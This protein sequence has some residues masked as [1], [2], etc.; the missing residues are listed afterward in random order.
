MWGL[1][2]YKNRD[3]IKARHSPTQ[4]YSICFLDNLVSTS[5]QNLP[6]HAIK[7]N[8]TNSPCVAF[9]STRQG[10]KSDRFSNQNLKGVKESPRSYIDRLIFLMI[11]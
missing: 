8:I 5:S 6:A 2:K 9:G 10:I 7:R 4:S 11:D 1:F 3:F